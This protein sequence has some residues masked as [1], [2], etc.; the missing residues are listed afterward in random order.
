MSRRRGRGRGRG[1]SRLPPEQGAWCGLHPRTQNHY[2]SRRQM[3]NPLSH[4]AP[5]GRIISK[6]GWV[7]RTKRDLEYLCYAKVWQITSEF[8]QE[9]SSVSPSLSS[10]PQCCCWSSH[11]GSSSYQF[12]ATETVVMDSNSRTIV[13]LPL[14]W[15]TDHFAGNCECP[16]TLRWCTF[17]DG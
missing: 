8:Q 3:L 6:L 14:G 10:L 12:A 17:T 15:H 4:P 7:I 2:L 1:R 13:L 9:H 16:Q 5:L 11:Q